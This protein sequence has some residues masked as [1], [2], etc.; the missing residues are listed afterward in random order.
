MLVLQTDI[1]AQKTVLEDLTRQVNTHRQKA[2]TLKAAFTKLYKQVAGDKAEIAEQTKALG[3]AEYWAGAFKEIRLELIDA[4]LTELSL[5]ATQHAEALGLSGW[6]I[7]F[8]TER[9]TKSG[10]L[11]AVFN[12]LLY[13]DQDEPIRFEAYSG[14][15]SQR[16]QLAIAF[17]LS[18]IVLARAG[19]T[20]NLAAFDEPTR[21]LSAEGVE[22]LLEH[23]ADR[24]KTLKQT[25]YVIEHHSLE[26]GAFD[27]TLLVRK[28]AAGSQLKEI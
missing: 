10:S 13:P 28:T 16:L 14:G 23:L 9:E 11:S 3:M 24:A 20:V 8:A 1:K 6:R 17:G 21:G 19:V 18:E 4:V 26:R 5:A 7:A 2:E 25:V 15:E 27:Q 22:A 12:V